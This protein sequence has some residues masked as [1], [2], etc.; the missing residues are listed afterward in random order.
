MCIHA[1]G[2]T[3]IPARIFSQSPSRAEC[4]AVARVIADGHQRADFLEE[5]GNAGDKP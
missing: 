2:G 4:P 5:F 3:G 1:P